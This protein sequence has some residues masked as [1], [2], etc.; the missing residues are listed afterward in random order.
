MVGL[1]ESLHA[2]KPINP[3]IHFDRTPICD[4]Q[5]AERHRHRAIA[6]II[7]FYYYATGST[8]AHKPH[9]HKQLNYISYSVARVKKGN[10]ERTIQG[11]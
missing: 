2:K 8:Q 1:V 9:K 7:I 11:R 5:Q 6:N 4:R 10:V 3:F